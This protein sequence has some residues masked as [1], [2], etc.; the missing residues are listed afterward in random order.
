NF[1]KLHAKLHAARGYDCLRPPAHLPRGNLNP[2]ERVCVS[3]RAPT[4]V[5][6][7]ELETPEGWSTSHLCHTGHFLIKYMT[8]VLVYSRPPFLLKYS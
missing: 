1:V 6:C 4:S 7:T 8:G 2:P 3:S 5:V